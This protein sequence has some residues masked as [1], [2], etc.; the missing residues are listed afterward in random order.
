[1]YLRLQLNTRNKNEIAE[2]ETNHITFDCH[3][4]FPFFPTTA[5]NF[6][7]NGRSVD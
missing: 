5:S 3:A 1:M 4:R 2:K 7:F 6:N